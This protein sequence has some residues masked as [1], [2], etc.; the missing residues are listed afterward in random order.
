MQARLPLSGINRVDSTELDIL[1]HS[2]MLNLIPTAAIVYQ[3]DHDI[4]HLANDKFIELSHYSSDE[5]P[6]MRLIDLLTEETDTNITGESFRPVC[7]R[8][9]D[10]DLAQSA[11]RVFS[12]NVSNTLVVLAFYPPDFDSQATENTIRS[13]QLYMLDHFSLLNSLNE[14]NSS[15]ALWLACAK[16]AKK[17]LNAPI[18]GLYLPQSDNKEAFIKQDLPSTFNSIQLPKKV[19]LSTSKIPS[20]HFLWQSDQT[21]EHPLH[22]FTLSKD[23]NYAVLLPVRD[24]NECFAIF[25]ATGLTPIP[26]IETMRFLSVLAN[27]A[28]SAYSRLMT[29]ENASKRLKTMRHIV[30][31]DRGITE[32]M[33]EGLIVL[34]PELRI[35]EM[36]FAAENI[37]GYASNEVFLQDVAMVLIGNESFAKL[38]KSAQQGISTIAGTNLLL[39]DRHGNA[40]PAQLTCVPIIID[41]EVKSI[42]ILMRD[43]S[44][45][46]QLLQHSKQLEQ[47]AFLG[48]VSAVFAHEVKN[49]INSI[50]TGLQFMGMTMS[51]EDPNYNLVVRLQQD[52]QRLTHLTDSTLTFAKPIEYHPLPLNLTSLLES[53]LERWG[54]RMTRL[55]ISYLFESEPPNATV[56]ADGRA[57]EQVFVNLISNG[58]QAMD[59]DGGSLSISIK[60]AEDSQPPQYE[61]CVADTGPGIPEDIIKHI[62]E[63]FQTTKTTG[64]GL[65]LAITKRIVTAHKGNIF[66]ES[67]PGGTMFRV[68]LPMAT[69]KE[70]DDK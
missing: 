27:H 69:E 55:N 17:A 62:F 18:L 46:E 20:Y 44:Q 54:P 70:T 1:K 34:T 15:R 48:E 43:L 35:A 5:L 3:R 8:L 9:A 21:P 67:Y 49:P 53:I 51:P 42:I 63:P 56:L 66:V 38:Y 31:I 33:S 2:Q 26:S 68:L 39:N 61:V 47:R 6:S 64:T 16:I 23:F 22:E 37:L 59:S 12:L 29:L 57:I 7:L 58:I 25:F 11:M 4:I 45:T 52:C 10:G 60:P 36:N 30:Q 28:K 40:F 41:D 32:N 65:G 24:E 19:G 13:S 50:S 14:Q